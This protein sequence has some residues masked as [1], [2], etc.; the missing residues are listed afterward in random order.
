MKETLPFFKPKKL[1]KLLGI[2]WE[3][4][5]GLLWFKMVNGLNESGAIVRL[6]GNVYYDK[7]KFAAW[8]KTPVVDHNRLGNVRE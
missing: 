6:R 5:Q 8:L 1:A 3:Q 4:M 7:D 2:S